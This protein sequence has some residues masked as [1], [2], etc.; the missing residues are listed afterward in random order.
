[1]TPLIKL[2]IAVIIIYFLV[3]AFMKLTKWTLRAVIIVLA[4]AIF[5]FGYTSVSEMFETP[6]SEKI[7]DK[8][9]DTEEPIILPGEEMIIELPPKNNITLELNE[10]IN[11]LDEME[12]ELNESEL[13]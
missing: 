10:T 8:F 7:K 3:T 6:P 13:V 11:I 9:N 4:I 5:I 2:L 1:M 12:A